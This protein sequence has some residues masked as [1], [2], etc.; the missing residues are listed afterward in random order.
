MQK[1]KEAVAAIFDKGIDNLEKLI[2]DRARDL[3]YA[4]IMAAKCPYIVISQM[5]IT[6]L[7]EEKDR[8]DIDL[9]MLIELKTNAL[10]EIENETD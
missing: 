4:R 5:D 3:A 9:A 7:V 1:R 2:W 6:R 10:Q 8:L